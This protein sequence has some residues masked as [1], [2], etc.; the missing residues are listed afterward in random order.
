[1][2][3]LA[4][5]LLR[6]ALVVLLLVPVLV[7]VLLP[8]WASR[9][10]AG[11]PEVAYLVIP[12]SVAAIL[13]IACGQVALLAIWRLLSL[14]Q[15]GV[16]FTRPAVRWAD[17]IIACAAVA[18]TLTTTVLVHM[19]GFVPGGGGP[20]IYLMTLTIAGCVTFVLFMIVMRGLLVAA[21]ADRAELD[22]VI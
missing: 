8:V 10:A 3:T 1:M 17:I 6:V 21:V 22:E 12:Y 5:R 20:T 4:I 2:Q 14:V 9:S 18:A 11:M 13:F 7:Q 15:G 16:I 19:I